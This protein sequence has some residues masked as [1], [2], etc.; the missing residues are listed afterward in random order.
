MQCHDCGVVF[1]SVWANYC[2]LCNPRREEKAAEVAAR[3]AAIREV[4]DEARKLGLVRA[5]VSDFNGR[6]VRAES[7][8]AGKL[9][10]PRPGILGP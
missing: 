6:H 7:V 3:A 10:D 4:G 1:N 9:K 5:V 8:V 2:P